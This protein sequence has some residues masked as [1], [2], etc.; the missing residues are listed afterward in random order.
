MT[1]Q[2]KTIIE[3]VQKLLEL[4]KG[5]EAIDSLKE[6]ANAAE[7]VQKL[8][9]KYNLEMAD[10]TRHEPK[11]KSAM[12]KSSY[13]EVNAKKNEGRW[14]YDLYSALARH[15]FCQLILTSYR[16]ENGKKNKY[17]NLVGTKE[18][19]QVVKF[20]AEQLE[21]RLRVLETRAWKTEGIWADEKRN[22]F[23]RGYFMGA[24]SGIGSQL[25]EVKRRAMQESVKVTDLVVQTDKQLN[26][27]VALIFPL[28]RNGRRTKAPSAAIAGSL[29]Y[30]DG[31][32]I[33]INRGVNGNKSGTPG[34][35][36]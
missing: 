26:D 9:L 10:I 21:S 25:S 6:A 28:L 22:A 16:M 35:L 8:L 33:N 12:G 24:C 7:K 29:G 13:R 1:D 15:N 31:K 2:N 27:A 14:I 23:R 3:R 19:V 4:Q 5:A 36:Q 18:N 11:K 34:Y 20:L 32:S 30:R 17:V